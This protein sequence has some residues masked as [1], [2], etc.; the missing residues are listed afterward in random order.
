MSRLR[1]QG[2]EAGRRARLQADHAQ[3]DVAAVRGR[4]RRLRRVPRRRSR[5]WSRRA[6]STSPRTRRCASPTRSGAI[7]GAL[8]AVGEG[9]RVR[10]AAHSRPRRPT[11]SSSRRT[12]AATPPAATRSSSR[13]PSGRKGPGMNPEG[14][15]V[16]V[17]ARA[18]GLFVGTYFEEAGAG[19][20]KVDG[21]TF[22]DPVY[23]GDP[24]AKGA[25]PGDKVAL[26]MVRYPTPVPRRRGGHH[27]D[28]RPA[29]P[30]GGRHPRRHPRLQHPRRLRRR[31]PSTRPASRPGTS[32][33]TR[34][35]DRLDLRDV[36][37]VTIDPATA[38]DFDD[39]ITLS[40]D[41]RGLLEPGRPHRRRLALRPRRL[42]PRPDRPA[43]RD[44]RLP[45]RPG[46]PDAPG[47]PLEQPGE[48]PGGPRPGTPSAPCMEFNAEGVRTDQ[49]FARSAIRVDHRFTYEQAF[50]VMKDP[51][52]DRPRGSRPRSSRMLGAD[53]R[54]GDDP[55]QAAV[56]ARGAGAEHARGRDR[57][58]R[59]GRGRRRPPRLAR[60]E[61]PGD[62]GVHARGQRGGGDVPDRAARR[63]PPPRRTPTPSR[64][65]SASSPSSPAASASTID[66]PQSRFELQRVLAETA[67]KPEAYAVHYGL[68][69]EPEAGRLH[70]RA[71]GPLRPGQRRLLPLH[72]ADPPL[73]RPPGPPPAHRAARR[74]RSP[75]ATTTS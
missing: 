28:P 11:R 3:G 51:D 26:E 45:A 71:R 43:P 38:R 75:R 12:P 55:P 72:L 49:Q 13:S 48:P 67:G 62:R 65:S 14:R 70:A 33:R 31:R 59:P 44:E 52:G 17:L 74:A 16:Q 46:H 57:P 27:R 40:R 23:V 73:P 34:S 35:S 54:A 37:T 30:A 66:Q 8:P 15:I 5:G 21:T 68:L 56:R 32:P 42:E 20:V 6:G 19:F 2:P 61:P 4:A 10:P 24:G 47:G 69:A 39:A 7:I 53:A 41:D 22:H 1:E 18:S 9:V 29:R 50:A 60:R 64:R 36:L 63:L 25:K 58:G